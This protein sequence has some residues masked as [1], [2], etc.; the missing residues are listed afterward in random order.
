MQIVDREIKYSSKTDI[1]KN[2]F[3]G[4]PHFGGNDVDKKL[5][6][7]CMRII[8]NEQNHYWTFGGDACEYINP[9]DK[10]YEAA[11]IDPEIRMCDQDD[12][13]TV[14]MEMA[15]N[16]MSVARDDCLGM[17]EGNHEET[18]RRRYHQDIHKEL[19]KRMNSG[20]WDSGGSFNLSY[21]AIVRLR[22]IRE[23][24]GSDHTRTVRIYIHHGSG[25]AATDGA[26]L[27][28]LAKMATNFPYEDVYVI[29]H[30][31]RR[32]AHTDVALMSADRLRELRHKPRAY[33]SAGTFKKTYTLGKSGYGEKRMYP[34]TALGCVTLCMIPD[35]HDQMV[36]MTKNRTDG[37]PG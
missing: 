29:N 7:E 2:T 33:L 30:I 10:R 32:V 23:C 20:R 12:L 31:H 4:D 1:I 9:S 25:S 13:A 36:F 6:R 28:R 18:I 16:E 27:N 37:L 15:D 14:Q 8:H 34:P 11:L 22:L 24:K 5:F 35:M 3:V 21:S 26:A 17:C 19:C